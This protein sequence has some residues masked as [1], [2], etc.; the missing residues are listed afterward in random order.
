MNAFFWGGHEITLETV[1]DFLFLPSTGLFRGEI[2]FFMEMGTVT[3]GYFAE[4]GF[5]KEN[6]CEELLEKNNNV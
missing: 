3:H 5:S 4:A 1:R 6:T 2:T